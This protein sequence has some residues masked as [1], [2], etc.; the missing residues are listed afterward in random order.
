MLMHL[1]LGIKSYF[2]S[3]FF[4][5]PHGIG[6][7]LISILFGNARAKTLPIGLC[8]NLI[9]NIVYCAYKGSK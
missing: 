8:E 3:D 1:F 2:L 5:D 7:R 4:I 6:T 9:R